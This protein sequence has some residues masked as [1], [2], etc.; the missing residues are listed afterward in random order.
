MRKEAKKTS[1]LTIRCTPE[2]KGDFIEVYKKA[3]LSGTQVLEEAM[4]KFIEY[5]GENC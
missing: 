2:L 5:V 4:R 1:M 3:G